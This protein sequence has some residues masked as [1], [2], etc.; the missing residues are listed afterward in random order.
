MGACIIL[1]LNFYIR[2]RMDLKLK[3]LIK[4]AMNLFGI[5]QNGRRK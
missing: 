5:K 3:K 1:D 4:I 2:I